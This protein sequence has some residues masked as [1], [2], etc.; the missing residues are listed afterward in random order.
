MTTKKQKVCIIGAGVVGCAIAYT[1]SKNKDLQVIV[2]E[3]N[4]TIP[5]LNQSSR[6]AGVIHAGIY[7][8]KEEEP[9]KAK[10][11]IE[12]NKL[13]Y[14]F[15]EKEGVPYK[16]VGKLI[17]A[18]NNLEKEYL[19]YFY[20]SAVANKVSGIRKISEKEIKE[21]EPNISALYALH[22]PTSGIVDVSKLVSKLKELGEKN[23]VKF[24]TG[25]KVIDIKFDVNQYIV[26]T[27]SNKTSHFYNAD[28]IINSAG[29]YSD[30]VAK[31]INKNS[32]FK[33]EQSRGEF[34]QFDNNSDLKINMNVYPAPHGLYKTNG[35]KAKVGLKEF[36]KLYKDGLVIRTVGVHITPTLTSHSSLGK[37]AIVGPAKTVKVAKTDYKKQLK[38]TE[39]F[40]TKV[41][42]YH[43]N[44]KKQHLRLHYAGIMAPE[45]NIKDFTIQNDERFPTFI[46]L[47]GID[48]PGMTSSLA[49][50]NYVERLVK[51][52]IK[53]RF[54]T[55]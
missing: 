20:E 28:L 48:S 33:I 19:D 30:S 40:F 12:G 51:K 26:K 32:K 36:L 43:P 9:L 25:A 37:V 7:Y 41:T 16:K 47:V 50:A 22:L 44:L 24:L 27:S 31:M 21:L 14:D 42:H 2:L 8:S 35:E 5:G 4:K 55:S 39:H 53:A 34:A 6:N 10:L 11:C 1:L 52:T 38:N 3:K 46:N 45:K 23:D 54:I 49:I 13:L 17:I 18:T 29:L 15:C